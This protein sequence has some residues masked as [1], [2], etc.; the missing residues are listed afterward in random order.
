MFVQTQDTPNPNSLKFLPGVPV[1]QNETFEFTDR[2]DAAKKSPLANALF[3][4]EGVKSVFFGPDFITISK[5]DED[6]EWRVLKPEIFAVIVD[7]FSSG[8]PVLYEST[9]KVDKGK[10][11]FVNR[12][13]FSK[14][15]P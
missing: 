9:N 2:L 11:S 5:Q 4:I 13:M 6:I 10:H 3:K 12:C 15:L 14:L 7:F 8:L 1:V